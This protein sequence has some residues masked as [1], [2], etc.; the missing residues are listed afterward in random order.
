[1]IQKIPTSVNLM[2]AVQIPSSRSSIK[3]A[4]ATSPCPAMGVGPFEFEVPAPGPSPAQDI[5]NAPISANENVENVF[6]AMFPV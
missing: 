5:A 2:L 6:S 3:A 4:T 1:M